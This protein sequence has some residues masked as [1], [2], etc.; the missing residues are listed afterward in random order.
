MSPEFLLYI[1]PATGTALIQFIIGG[2]AG[3]LIAIKIFWSSIKLK[4]G[5]LF[6]KK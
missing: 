5:K 3:A 4:L 6:D 1:D 2:L